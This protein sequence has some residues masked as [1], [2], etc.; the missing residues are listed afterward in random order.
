M[1]TKKAK[2]FYNAHTL[3][4]EKVVITWRQRILRWMGSGM[5]IV[6]LTGGVLLFVYYTNIFDSP[7][8]KQQAREIAKMQFE[9]EMLDERLDNFE[10]ILRGLQ[11]RDDNIYRVIFEAEPIPESVR[12]AGF[13]GS[14]KY[15]ALELYENSDLMISTAT[16]LDKLSKQL[17]IQSKS[18]DEVNKMI[19]NK[20]EM[21]ASIPAIQPIANNDLQRIASGFGYRIHPI[22]KTTRMHTG[23]DFTAPTG[24]NI[25]CTGDGIV[26]EVD[27]HAREYGRNVTVDHGFGYKTIYAH[28]SE[29]KV[30]RGQKV[31]RGDVLGTVG[32]TGLSTA[33]HLH[34]E[35]VRNGAKIDPVNFFYNDLT[36]EEYE[37]VIELSTQH[38]QSFD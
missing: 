21:L 22:Y 33:P 23:I 34:Y 13:G 7:K 14:S 25:Y 1:P 9:Y 3:K 12:E 30:K 20:T 32:S 17:Y 24:T 35:V 28:M 16:R 2:Y 10:A 19:K 6:A 36:P 5:V 29:C 27:Y 15:R 37:R 4:Y 18:Y 38:N 31:K 11:D 26:A 8:E